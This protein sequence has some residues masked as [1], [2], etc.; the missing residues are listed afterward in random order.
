MDE[1]RCEA[2]RSG[3]WVSGFRCKG[4][5]DARPADFDPAGLEEHTQ[6]KIELGRGARAKHFSTRHGRFDLKFYDPVEC[7]SELLG[8]DRTKRSSLECT[9]P[10]PDTFP[11]TARRTE[12]T[13]E[14]EDELRELVEK[15]YSE[16]PSSAQMTSV[17]WAEELEAILNRHGV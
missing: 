10:A 12:E 17:L 6:T 2:I 14:L 7:R 16:T 11:G 9:S 8:P 15:A 1:L 4:M 5:V 13:P 3:N